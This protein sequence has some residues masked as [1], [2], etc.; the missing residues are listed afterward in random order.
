[1]RFVGYEEIIVRLLEAPYQDT[2]SAMRVNGGLSEWFDAVVE[3]MQG[4]IL[5]QLLFNI[6]LEAVMAVNVSGINIS[7]FLFADDICL[8]AGSNKDLQQ[9]VDH[10]TSNRFGLKV[11]NTK[12]EVQYIGREKQ[13]TKI[14]LGSSELTQFVYLGGVI[15]EDTSCD[16]DVTRRIGLAAGTVRNLHNIRKANDISKSTKVLLYQTLV[17]AIILYNSE[18]WTLK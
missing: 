3:V 5:S 13:H 18:T 12:T 1:M 10:T 15:S 16:E 6:L 17:R 8:A 11:S 2:M 9:L 4:C 14:M 7:N